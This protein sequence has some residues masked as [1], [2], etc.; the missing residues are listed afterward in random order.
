MTGRHGFS[1]LAF[2]GSPQN[3]KVF[4]EQVRLLYQG[5]VEAHIVTAINVVLL[6]AIQRSVIPHHII[7]AWVFYMFVVTT[8]RALLVWAY[9]RSDKKVEHAWEWNQYYLAGS[10][11]AG[12]GWGTAGVFLY[13]P[14]SLAH[15]VFLAFV[16]GGMAAG[17]VAVLTPR[18]DVFFAF[19]L[20]A[21]SALA[22]RFFV[23]S[24][25]YHTTMTAMILLYGGALLI[26]ARRFHRTIQS[27]LELR[28]ENA[29]LVRH[30]TRAKEQAEA[31]NEDLKREIIER[32]KTETA[33]QQACGELERTVEER[34]ADKE[35]LRLL[36]SRLRR[37]EQRIRQRLATEL[38][39]NIAQTLA[40]CNMKL[41]ALMEKT[42]GTYSGT[43]QDV[44][45]HVNEALTSTRGLMYDLRPFSLSTGDD[46]LTA[47]QWV[48]EKARRHGLHVI[49]EDD[50]K[51]KVL[52][53][54]ALTVLYQS[55]H[56]A[57]FNVLKHAGTKRARVSLRRRGN[58]V[59]VTVRDKGEGF[60]PATIP[61]PNQDRGF[62]LFNMREQLHQINGKLKIVS[63]PGK[64]TTIIITV[65][66]PLG[67][68]GQ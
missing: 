65:P 30:L 7:L 25:S 58:H 10:G 51:P 40:F 66:R 36:S 23:D 12:A 35:Q 43:L 2:C 5:A 28:C 1:L 3:A 33:L 42:D 45:T 6:A 62:G 11:L 52:D 22:V 41:H 61:V 13:P 50:T 24:D 55:I 63:V 32:R 29:E 27:T 53:E 9:W 60:N 39:D 4:H 20:P 56:E 21:I 68:I 44:S 8:G 46:F 48:A 18:I 14:D 31:L 19:F 17:A 38:H 37:N 26:A 47:V 49:I 15:Q 54:E 59:V 57:L 67:D 16:I 34:T 64:G